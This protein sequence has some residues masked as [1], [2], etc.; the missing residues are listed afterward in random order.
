MTRPLIPPPRLY[1]YFDAIIRH[2]S[3]RGAAEALRV[4]SSAL[5]RRLLDLE[6][7]VG[8]ILFDRMP[9]G[10]RLTP[11]GEIFA[12]HVRRTLGDVKL[13]S[14]Q[15]YELNGLRGGHVAIGSAESAALGLLPTMLASFRTDYPDARFTVEV[16]TPREILADLLDDRVD[17]ILTHEEPSHHDVA[18]VTKVSMPFCALMRA[19]HPL[20][21][22]DILYLK[23][24]QD[25]PAVLAQ[26]QLAARALVDSTLSATSLQMHPVL[27]T[28]MFEL[29]KKFVLQSE[30]ISFQFQLNVTGQPGPDG[31]VAIKLADEQLVSAHLTLAV[32]RGRTL[33]PGA[34]VLVKRLETALVS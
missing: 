3:I 15:I 24:C 31:V 2:G 21:G 12:A 33:A 10:V 26:E 5:N 11:A 1:I 9:N 29:M 28:N 6:R 19:G 17:M 20:A 23:D 7:E 13:V 4:A 22:R 25:Y 32:R 34:A 14:D 30:A 8:T 18:V 27:V 16:G